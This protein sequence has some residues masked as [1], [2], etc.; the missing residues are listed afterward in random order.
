M[1]LK[2]KTKAKEYHRNYHKKWYK[3]N[4]IKQIAKQK[5]RRQKRV[6]WLRD[7]KVKR[8]CISCDENHPAALVFHHASDDKEFGIA[9]MPN[10]FGI[11]RIKKE[12]DKCIVMC[13]NCHAKG[14]WNHK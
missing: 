10:N 4:R 8:G 14:H 6:D 12:V 3:K 5:E 9:E 11:E 13:R 2:D 7:Y 1:P